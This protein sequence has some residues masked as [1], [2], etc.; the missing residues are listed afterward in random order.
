MRALVSPAS[1]CEFDKAGRILLPQHLRES[2]GIV[3]EVFVVGAVDYVELWDPAEYRAA[4]EVQ[5]DQL[6]EATE[7]IGSF[8]AD[9][10]KEGLSS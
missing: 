1:E 3:K 8:Y 4:T 5:Q 9:R 10:R 2:V 6:L 7:K